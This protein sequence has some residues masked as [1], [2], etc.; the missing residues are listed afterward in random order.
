MP[1]R[2]AAFDL[3]GM[4]IRG[5]DSLAV[6][7]AALRHPEWE[8]RMEILYVRGATPEE[9]GT[10]VAPWRTFSTEELCRP[11]RHAR[12]GTRASHQVSTRRVNA[13]THGT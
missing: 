1:I 6:I 2:L 4:L 12:F 13:C 9:M 8:H 3:D 5:Q 11:L 10:R 7:G